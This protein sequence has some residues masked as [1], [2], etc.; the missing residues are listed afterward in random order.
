[1]IAIQ[2]LQDAQVAIQQLQDQITNLTQNNLN[3]H[4]RSISNVGVSTN[5]T[6]V[7]NKSQLK[8]A[9]TPKNL[10]GSNRTS[11][12]G[13]EGT[14][15]AY[16]SKPNVFQQKNSFR[17]GFD[18]L[19]VLF[20][21]AAATLLSTSQYYIT[22]IKDAVHGLCLY[23]YNNQLVA[24]DNIDGA[25]PAGL[26]TNRNVY[27]NLSNTYDLG[28]G[29]ANS[30]KSIF[31]NGARVEGSLDVTGLPAVLA[32]ELATGVIQQ[33]TAG[34][35]PYG[36][37]T[38]NGRIIT[39]HSITAGGNTSIQADGSFTAVA[40]FDIYFQTGTFYSVT[41]GSHI[42]FT[43]NQ[44]LGV[45]AGTDF[46]VSAGGNIS[47]IGSGTGV[48]RSS[49][50]MGIESVSGNLYLRGGAAI[51]LVTGSLY[52]G[53]NAGLNY[54]I[55]LAKLTAG[56]SNGSITFTAGIATGKVDPT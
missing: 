28:K 9:V 1:M 33:A 17:S 7:V 39:L 8:Q 2:S 23:D 30:W 44:Y 16:L 21:Q 54:T 27:P 14:D 51:R 12:P 40:A 6:S 36:D 4:G 25:S 24:R 10:P 18:T 22:Y 5:P 49:G 29:N 38:L 26:Y 20:R 52:I 48:Y 56:G 34:T 50:D 42:D 55:A 43:A 46:T 3:L 37:L 41:S 11:V 53:A 31:T 47:C 35:Y 45:T 13:L 32:L 15:L 19:I